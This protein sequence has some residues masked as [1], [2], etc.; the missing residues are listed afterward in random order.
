MGNGRISLMSCYELRIITTYDNEKWEPTSSLQVLIL[1]RIRSCIVSKTSLPHFQRQY[2]IHALH[3][4]KK[5]TDT[6]PGDP[7]SA[8]LRI[9]TM[10]A[11]GRLAMA[12]DTVHDKPSLQLLQEAIP[13]MIAVL[14]QAVN[15]GDEIRTAQAF[16]TCQ[17]LLG[18][19][20]SVL[21]RCFGDLVQFMISLA[22]QQTLDED[23]RTQALSFLMQCITYRKLKMRAL[24]VG[25][26][27]TLRCLEIA[28]EL[29]DASEDDEDV[30][31]PRAALGL[32]DEM[33]AGLPPSQV[34]VPLLHA[35]GPYVSSPDPDRRQAGIVALAMCVE[36][37]PEFISTQLKEILPQVIRLIDDSDPRVR[38]AAMDCVMRLAEELPEDL[39]KEHMKLLPT[40]V[41]QMDIAMNTMRRPDDKQ[42]LDIIKTSV[43]CIDVIVQGLDSK[44]IKPYLSDLMLRLSKLVSSDIY[45]IKTAAISATGAIAA[46]AKEEFNQ[47]FEETM[48]SL[49]KYVDFKGSTEEQLNLRCYTYDAITSTALG[50]G[51]ELFKNYVKRLMEETDQALLLNHPQLKETSFLFWAMMAKV[52]KNH[53]EGFLPDVTKALFEILNTEEAPFGV[54]LGDEAKD[55]AG[56]EITIGGRKV[57]ISAL[58][59]DDIIAAEDIEDFDDEDSATGSDDGWDVVT[60]L[61][62]EKEMAVEVLGDILTHATQS[63]IPYMEQ[64]ITLVVPLLKHSYE[65][66]RK[67]AISTLF[68]AYTA[69]WELQPDSIKNNP[70]GLPLDPEPSPEI[71]KLGEIIMKPT[72]AL[73]AVEKD[74]YVRIALPNGIFLPLR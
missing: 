37:A 61:E 13:H 45:R 43:T 1:L 48:K 10:L 36:G 31:T 5:S 70:S 69:C 51:P 71:K 47:Y 53:F 41:R 58:T 56:K 23:C 30:T 7:E 68:R 50:V 11:M 25:E 3:R 63:Y 66:I 32:L 8:E 29:G 14:K 26:Q 54:D 62:Q 27:L 39:G 44:D 64:T 9:T 65:G 20:F 40:V 34:V 16:E 17:I 21:K 19:K 33:A 12:L 59:V 6:L 35:F 38:R 2:V 57:K 60:A 46:C 49:R 28:C 72:L 24:R 67:A 42:N 73:W 4:T 18:C 15:E 52:Y 55:L 74:R 22:T